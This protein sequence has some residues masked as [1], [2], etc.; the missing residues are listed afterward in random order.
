[1]VQI[2][3]FFADRRA[4]MKITTTK[5]SHLALYTCITSL[6]ARNLKHEIFPGGL[7]GEFW[8]IAPVKIWY[9]SYGNFMAPIRSQRNKTSLDILTN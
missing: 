7:G 2:F 4:S 9:P 8:K 5:M 3:A 6:T 1:M